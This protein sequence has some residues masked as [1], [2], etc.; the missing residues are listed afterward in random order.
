M[1]SQQTIKQAE[2]QGK[3]S[4]TFFEATNKAVSNPYTTEPLATAWRRG[5]NKG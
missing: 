1:N 4:W 5:W 3:I 2:R